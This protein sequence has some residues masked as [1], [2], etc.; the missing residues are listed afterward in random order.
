MLGFGNTRCGRSALTAG[1]ACDGDVDVCERNPAGLYRNALLALY[2]ADVAGQVVCVVT[3]SE[4]MQGRSQRATKTMRTAP[5]RCQPG[6][7]AGSRPS[8][9][10]TTTRTPVQRPPGRAPYHGISQATRVPREWTLVMA[11]RRLA[12]LSSSA[13]VQRVSGTVRPADADQR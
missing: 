10:N 3:V 13:V 9:R 8:G 12:T 5:G 6:M 1:A 2:D 7:V 11:P 4:R